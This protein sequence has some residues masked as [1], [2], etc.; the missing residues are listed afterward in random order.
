MRPTPTSG[1]DGL[2]ADM[3]ELDDAAQ[4]ESGRSSE[5]VAAQYDPRRSWLIMALIMAF[6]MIN[7]A[8]KAV[9]GFAAVP[10]MDELHISKSTYG[11]IASSFFLLFGITSAVC[12]FVS[13]RVRTKT[14]L[15]VLAMTWAIAMVPVLVV[16]AVPTLLASRVILGA[17]E[18]P[19]S[20]MSMHA[21]Y[22]WFPPNKRALPSALQV[23]GGAVGVFVAT[24]ILGAIIDQ[25]GWRAGFAAPAIASVV[26]SVLW[27]RASRSGPN[28][29][30]SSDPGVESPADERSSAARL[31]LRRY[32]TTAS[33]LGCLAC[34]FGAYWAL[35]LQT[36][37]LPAYLESELGMTA[38]RGSLVVAT[39]GALSIVLLLT[40]V[41]LT[42]AAIRR[43]IPS[44][45]A[46]GV[47][48]GAILV[49]CGACV[50]ALPFVDHLAMVIMLCAMAFGG[51]AVVYPLV[52]LTAGEII[53]PNYRGAAFGGTL[54]LATLPGVIAPLLTGWIV[55][56][57]A[58]SASG[59]TQ[60]F[61]VAAVVMIVCGAIAMLTID[62][63]RDGRRLHGAAAG[64]S[65]QPLS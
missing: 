29:A 40:V 48:Q 15:L 42:G 44:R 62:P 21:L 36:A 6:M 11:L 3:I 61:I 7:F 13:T 57:A 53:P 46:R 41:P 14:I 26:W 2:T 27:Y 24:P 54:A 23:A 35:A 47:L 33:T 18:G 38:R 10:I 4:D 56:H 65:D 22:E 45:W 39:C 32:L 17:A 51:Q 59:F 43:G 64:P 31:P 16:A 49:V 8:D 63:D 60:A 52:Y 37:W 28:A 25:Y 58:S 50:L 55:D 12:G 20:P 19:A 9:L 1:R 5:S 30:T 34:A